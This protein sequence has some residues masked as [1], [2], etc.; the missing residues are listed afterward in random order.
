MMQNKEI[1]GKAYAALC[2]MTQMLIFYYQIISKARSE[3]FLVQ[4][5]IRQNIRIK[6]VKI[7]TIVSPL[8]HVNY[9]GSDQLLK[10]GFEHCRREK[11]AMM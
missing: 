5:A 2:S 11:I 3:L 8:Y 9:L 4:R 6:N 7:T 10:Q 1:K